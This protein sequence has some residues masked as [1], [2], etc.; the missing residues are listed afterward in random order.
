MKPG[1]ACEFLL[2]PASF[3]NERRNFG[4]NGGGV[5]FAVHKGIISEVRWILNT[6]HRISGHSMVSVVPLELPLGIFLPQLDV[7]KRN[8]PADFKVLFGNFPED[9][10]GNACQHRSSWYFFI[11]ANYCA[12]SDDA[13][14]AND[15][16]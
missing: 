10:C 14:F 12:C 11:L 16:A 13:F 7:A 2:V 8:S 6:L 15:A 9:L 5:I 1:G 3:F 4:L